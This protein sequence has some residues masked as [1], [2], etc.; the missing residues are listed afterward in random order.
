MWM[1]SPFFSY[2]WV[3]DHVLVEPDNPGRLSAASA[4][5]R[6]AMMA[7]LGLRS[8]NEKKFSEWS[9]TAEALGLAFDT[10][11]RTVSMPT[12]KLIKA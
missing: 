9:T 10:E 7:V 8:I 5:L 11:K 12:S 3:D 1:Q 2:E 6:L 4:A